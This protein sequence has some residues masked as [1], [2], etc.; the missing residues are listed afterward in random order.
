[1]VLAVCIDACKWGR[2]GCDENTRRRGATKNIFDRVIV[3]RELVKADPSIDNYIYI[4]MWTEYWRKS[5][6][7]T[8]D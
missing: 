5:E 4:Y 3:E 7:R 2:E 6:V 1:V 8:R